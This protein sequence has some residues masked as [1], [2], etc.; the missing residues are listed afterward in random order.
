MIDVILCETANIAEVD[1]SKF[2][3]T[4]VQ[5]ENRDPNYLA[6]LVNGNF[7]LVVRNQTILD[8]DTLRVLSTTCGNL[9]VI[10]RL[11]VGLDNI[12]VSAAKRFGFKIV[13]TPD[14]NTNS[15]SELTFAL[16]LQALR[17]TC[18][19]NSST[20]QGNWDR[21]HFVG[22]EVSELTIGIVGF[23]RIGRRFAE[24]CRSLDAKEILV[25]TRTKPSECSWFSLC[26]LETLA[27]K[28]DV[29][30]FHVPGTEDTKHL[31]SEVLI[32]KLKKNCIIINTSRGSVLDEGAVERY[33]IENVEAIACLDVRQMEPPGA[34]P[35][36]R[37]D[38]AIL[39]PHI[40][41]F[42]QA[43]QKKVVSTVFSDIER[44]YSGMA[45]IYPA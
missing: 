14:A 15:T 28:S 35:L 4:E 37:L 8:E 11:G 30:S 27:E 31:L 34:S 44:I 13:Y 21:T 20:K 7:A 38:N 6:D 43:A 23:G 41:A 10:A 24:I 18:Q 19:A 17:K 36:D 39:T 22:R 26:D 16:L 45:A 42:T 29:I 3:I 2:N 40:G 32:G 5:L 9:R 25:S 12:D 1:R 33:L